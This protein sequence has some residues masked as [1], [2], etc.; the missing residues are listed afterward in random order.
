VTFLC[1]DLPEKPELCLQDRIS[2]YFPKPSVREPKMIP[3]TILSNLT[4]YF[5]ILCF[6]PDMV[7]PYPTR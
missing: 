1:P 4:D 5:M 6:S 7:L 2:V 3:A